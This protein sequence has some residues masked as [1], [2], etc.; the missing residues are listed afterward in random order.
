MSI[1]MS[2]GERFSAVFFVKIQMRIPRVGLKRFPFLPPERNVEAISL[3][4]LE[5]RRFRGE[6]QGEGQPRAQRVSR[7]GLHQI[8]S[9]TGLGLAWH[10][11]PRADIRAGL[12]TSTPG[13]E[14]GTVWCLEAQIAIRTASFASFR[15]K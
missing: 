6:G 14:T 8:S 3:L 10:P 5:C 15:E 4:S 7:L 11:G 9:M 13:P 12:G 1:K 2:L